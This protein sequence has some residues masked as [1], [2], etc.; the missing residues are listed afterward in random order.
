MK[1]LKVFDSYVFISQED[2]RDILHSAIQNLDLD[3]AL[4]D[5]YH[6]AYNN[7]EPSCYIKETEQDKKD[8]L[9][10][11]T[12]DIFDSYE[13]LEQENKELKEQLK[14]TVKVDFKIGDEVWFVWCDSTEI[15]CDIISKVF[16]KETGVMYVGGG[17]ATG[18]EKLKQDYDVIDFYVSN[19]TYFEFYGWD[20]DNI[21][22]LNKDCIRGV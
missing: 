22:V 19:I 6:N 13:K 11:L 7:T 12:N 20:C 21:L 15:I 1:N 14:G 10:E 3:L 2:Y 9:H 17:S 4:E 8:A 16:I 18:F 5:S